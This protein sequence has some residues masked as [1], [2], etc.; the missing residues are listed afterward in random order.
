MK[1]AIEGGANHRASAYNVDFVG[2]GRVIECSTEFS[3][4]TRDEEIEVLLAPLNSRGGRLSESD[5]E[6][7]V[8]L[9]GYEKARRMLDILSR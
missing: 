8:E 7:L 2:G 4:L 6:R 5:K 3:S 1:I 9:V